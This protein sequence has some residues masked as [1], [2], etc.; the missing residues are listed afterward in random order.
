MVSK[1]GAQVELVVP[2]F[3]EEA[4]LPA[5]FVALGELR[6]RFDFC[7]LLV[8]DGSG[9]A[10]GDLAERLLAESGLEGRVLR[11]EKN[12]GLTAAL[13][14]GFL[15]GRAPIQCWVDADL[16]YELDV[17]I[18]LVAELRAGADVATVSPY[19]PRGSTQ[20]VPRTRLW[21]SQGLS[22]LHRAVAGSAKVYT[23]SAMVRAWRRECLARCLP[24]R[25]GHLGVTESLLRAQSM[26]ARIAEVPATLK[27]RAAGSSSM[28]VMRV[29]LGQL[30]LLRDAVAGRVVADAAPPSSE[31]STR[32]EA[33]TSGEE[34]MR[35]EAP[36]SG[37]ESTRDEAQA[38]GEA[39]KSAEASTSAKAREAPQHSSVRSVRD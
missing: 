23:V 18:A 32:D 5:L 30:A 11:H 26:H 19:H 38:S 8:D 4:S 27:G 21:L 13:R 22:K 17:L 14:T 36:T 25:P 20:G 16:S 33:P 2:M 39:S 28:R 37:E 6:S 15:A 3:R 12:L 10:T 29:A 1:Q 9:D 7:V 35:D 34:S 24:T 31:E